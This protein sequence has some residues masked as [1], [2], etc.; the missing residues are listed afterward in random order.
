M[1]IVMVCGGLAALLATA[2]SAQTTQPAQAP[3]SVAPATQPATGLPRSPAGGKTV[4][5]VASG[6]ASAQPASPTRMKALNEDAQREAAA[7]E[8]RWDERMRRIT[9]SMCDRC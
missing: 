8:K 5:P 7:R 1:R 9:R 6:A 2:A 4:A 3:R